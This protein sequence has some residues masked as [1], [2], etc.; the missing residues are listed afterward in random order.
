MRL[1]SFSLLFILKMVLFSQNLCEN[2]PVITIDSLSNFISTSE[3]E[4]FK[5]KEDS[6]FDSF[7]FISGFK[8]VNLYFDT[9]NSLNRLELDSNGLV[10]PSDKMINEG[11]CFC[12]SCVERYSKISLQKSIFIEVISP[13]GL[14]ILKHKKKSKIHE[15]WY[16]KELKSGDKIRLQRIL[17]VGGEARFRPTSYQDLNRLYNVMAKNS[18]LKIEIQG[19]V[20][21]P[22]KRNTKKNQELSEARSKAVMNYLIQK[23]IKSDRLTSV[24]Y[25][26]TK[27]IYSNTKLEYE[28]QFNR[29]VE[30]LVK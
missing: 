26:N 8:S 5:V 12:K 2:V 21:S 9:C 16:E 13:S 3:I 25:G 1:T 14:K 27:M 15:Y 29:R 22:G 10:I 7:S 19:H 30:I 17:F 20:N 24:G 6:V 11:M 23:G 18:H 28:M 4:Y